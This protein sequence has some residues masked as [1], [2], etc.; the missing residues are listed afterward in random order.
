MSDDK[1]EERE[2]FE[3][4]LKQTVRVGDTIVYPSRQ[5]SSLWMNKAVVEKIQVKT[6]KSYY[7]DSTFEEWSIKLSSGGR[8]SQIDRAVKVVGV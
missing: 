2:S 5:S 1:I 6:R 3:D 7:N 4:F 8:L